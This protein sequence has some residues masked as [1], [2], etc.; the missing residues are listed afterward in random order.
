MATLHGPDP[1]YLK[2]LQAFE[3][4]QNRSDRA[5]ILGSY[6]GPVQF[7]R[8]EQRSLA[9]DLAVTVSFLLMT[10]IHNSNGHGLSYRELP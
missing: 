6:S 5:G 4:C 3:V 9:K 7:K 2:P 8:I 10:P 1:K